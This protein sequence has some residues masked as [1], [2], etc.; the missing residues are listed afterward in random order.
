MRLTVFDVKM[1]LMSEIPPRVEL[2]KMA[3]PDPLFPA[4]V[5]PEAT[6]AVLL[7]K[8]LPEINADCTPS[9]TG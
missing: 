7:M 5:E 1:L 4:N 3:P 9:S 2:K 8:M 6:P